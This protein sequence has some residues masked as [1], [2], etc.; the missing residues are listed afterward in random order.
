MLRLNLWM[1]VGFFLIAVLTVL[2]VVPVGVVIASSLSTPSLTSFFGELTLSNLASTLTGRNAELLVNTVIVAVGS[3][4]IAMV[5][6]TCLAWIVT[7][8]NVPFPRIVGLIP[9]APILLPSL[10]RDTAWIQLYSPRTGLVNL[11]LK[12]VLGPDAPVIDIFTLWGVS[13]VLGLQ[14]ASVAYI[15]VVPAFR[16]LS[17]SLEDASRLSGAGR[18]TT[19]RRVTIPLLKPAMLSAFALCALVAASAF[20]TPLL[21]G[22]PGGIVTYMSGIYRALT[23]GT[24]N[25]NLAAAQS[26]LFFILNG[27]LVS[28]YLVTTRRHFKFQTVVGRRDG[29][30]RGSTGWRFLLLLFPLT[31]FILAFGQLV[32]Q[33][34]LVSFLPYYTV[35]QGFPFKVLT[36]DNYADLLASGSTRS[37]ILNSM[38]LSTFATLLTVIVA[39]L[40]S[41][42]AFQTRVRGRRLVEFVGTI[43]LAIPALVL[44][45][46]LLI[47][48]ITIPGLKNLYGTLVPLVIVDL[49]LLLPYALRITSASMIQIAPELREAGAL[50]GAGPARRLGTISIP[51]IRPAIIGAAYVVFAL[52][53]RELAGVALLVGPNTPLIPTKALDLFYDGSGAPTVAALNT[54]TAFLPVV[55][56]GLIGLLLLVLERSQGKRWRWQGART[57][58]LPVAPTA[59]NDIEISRST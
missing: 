11:A 26:V 51:L 29:G 17:R 46:A 48:V 56:A 16:S 27:V 3:T 1:L 37:A 22:L 15:V 23:G 40:L 57:S 32:I 13:L 36:L 33:G 21:I 20:E 34:V 59:P 9:V 10:M 47:T 2:V 4:I 35:T 28:W 5:V 38:G 14:L 41:T 24:P 31:Y 43:P 44:S 54:V 19:F 53:L 6:A 55:S 25:Y 50:S 12:A 42:V 7:S 8:T 18:L 30:G 52:S 45:L 49:I 58:I 39:I